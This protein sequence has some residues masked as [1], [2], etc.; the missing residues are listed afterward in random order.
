MSV[1][2]TFVVG[3]TVIAGLESQSQIDRGE[4][5][6]LR[7]GEESAFIGTIVAVHNNE[8]YPS[9]NIE[10]KD[11]LRSRYE[12]GQYISFMGTD[13][14]LYTK[15]L[16]GID[17]QGKKVFNAAAWTGR[18]QDDTPADKIRAAVTGTRKWFRDLVEYNCP[19]SP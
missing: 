7:E 3:D 9:V 8:H 14:E 19:P 4:S 11:P 2:K 17:K 15:G 12:R 5:F 10:C 13:I 6:A 16:V 1:K 18:M